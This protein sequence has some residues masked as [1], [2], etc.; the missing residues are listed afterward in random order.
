VTEPSPYAPVE[1][2][3]ATRAQI[4]TAVETL[5]RAFNADPV[6]S[7]AF[8]D[9]ERRLEQHRV[10]WGLVAEAAL[11]YESAWLTGD[12]A[13]VALWI[14]PG[15]SELRPEDE[16]RLEGLLA[17][18]L[19]DGAARVLATFER[20]E[21]A[22]PTEQPHYYLSLLGTNPDYRGRGLGMSLL[23]ATLERIDAEGAPAFLE[24]S[25]PVNTPRYERLGFTVCGEIELPEDGPSVTQMWREPG[26]SSAASPPG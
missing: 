6:W 7:W 9:P 22:H 17:E 2:R 12:C 3:V 25:N 11:G 1:A 10:I 23:A 21:A 5:A 19:E 13:A 8:P 18:M 14:P 24:S 26:G 20:F 16:E 15:K 4:S